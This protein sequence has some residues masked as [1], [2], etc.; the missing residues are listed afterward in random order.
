MAQLGEG[1]TFDMRNSQLLTAKA[2]Q[3]ALVSVGKKG[4][5][6]L[7]LSSVRGAQV[8][9]NGSSIHTG[10]ETNTTLKSIHFQ[11][12][13][14]AGYGGVMFAGATNALEI[15]NVTSCNSKSKD[16]RFLSAAEADKLVVVFGQN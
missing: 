11:D 6:N 3:G 13:V 2:S 4:T 7:Y 16:N 15:Q 10:E 5:I 8:H 9:G 14:A 12:T 1:A